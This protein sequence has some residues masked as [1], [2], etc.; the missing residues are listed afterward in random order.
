MVIYLNQLV[1]C[2]DE[3][4]RKVRKTKYELSNENKRGNFK[5][6]DFELKKKKKL[7]E[8]NKISDFFYLEIL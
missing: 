6:S 1:R 8:K 3:I 5:K 2:I 7:N 4:L